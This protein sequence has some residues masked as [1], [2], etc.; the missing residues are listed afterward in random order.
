M[1]ASIHSRNYSDLDDAVF[2]LSLAAQ[3]TTICRLFLLR[4]DPAG[5]LPA[6]RCSVLA[7]EASYVVNA[8]VIIIRAGNCA[9]RGNVST[10]S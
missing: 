2:G 6:A 3:I 8:Y 9:V 1:V 7:H 5:A 10:T 4:I